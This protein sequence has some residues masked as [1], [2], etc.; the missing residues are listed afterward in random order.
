MG[1]QKKA[2][3]EVVNCAVVARKLE[4]G[5]SWSCHVFPLPLSSLAN[6]DAQMKFWAQS[7]EFCHLLWFFSYIMSSFVVLHPAEW[8]SQLCR[9]YCNPPMLLAVFPPFPSS[10]FPLSLHALFPRILPGTVAVDCNNACLLPHLLGRL[11]II[12]ISKSNFSGLCD[13]KMIW[14]DSC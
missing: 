3:G 5:S 2:G 12:G 4:G 9:H 10:S 11:W 8:H 14:R 7:L 13:M 6:S 1:I